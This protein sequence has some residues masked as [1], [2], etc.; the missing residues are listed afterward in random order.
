MCFDRTDNQHEHS[1][2]IKTS[3][4]L[5]ESSNGRFGRGW[6]SKKKML[7]QVLKTGAACWRQLAA[8]IGGGVHLVFFRC[9]RRSG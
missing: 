9:T 3:T 7:A 1:N 8:L 4:E 2:H 5:R 6:V